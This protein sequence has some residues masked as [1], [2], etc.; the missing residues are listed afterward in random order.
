[1]SSSLGDQIR[2]ARVSADLTLREL[3][4]RL[5]RAPSYI[6]D[7]EHN[8]RIPSEEVI[9]DIAAALQL[10]AD[11]LLSSAG[12]VGSEAVSYMQSNP[13]AGV[14]FRKVSGANLSEKDLES[15]LKQAD[16]LIDKRGQEGS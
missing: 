4:R 7:I 13:T 14:L 12:R 10:D 9:N 11:R 2:E 3:A 6:N 1:M 16:K 8:R 15:L 5:D